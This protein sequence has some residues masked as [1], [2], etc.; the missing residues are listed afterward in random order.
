MWMVSNLPLTYVHLTTVSPTKSEAP[1]S[2]PWLI[3]QGLLEG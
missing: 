2:L 3:P 1:P